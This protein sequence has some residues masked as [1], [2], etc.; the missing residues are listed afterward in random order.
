MKRIITLF[1][2]CLILA[3]AFLACAGSD[4]DA[5][6]TDKK[7]SMLEEVSDA[8]TS[9]AEIT[10][11]ETDTPD[12]ES[13]TTDKSAET[14]E[15]ATSEA[16]STEVVTTAPI[17]AE[18]ETSVPET[19]APSGGGSFGGGGSAPSLPPVVENCDNG[20][21]EV[22]HLA[23]APTCIEIGWNAY[24]TCSRCEYSTYEEIA[25][26]R[27]LGGEVPAFSLDS[28]RVAGQ[29]VF[30][31]GGELKT[32]L[33]DGMASLSE[34]SAYRELSPVG[35]A[36]D[37]L[38]NLE[39]DANISTTPIGTS[40]N[41]SSLTVKEIVDSESV[42]YMIAEDE[43]SYYIAVQK[44]S[45]ATADYVVTRNR[46]FFD[47][48]LDV[49][50]P[51]TAFSFDVIGQ[52]RKDGWAA[53]AND[54][55]LV[56]N[57]LDGYS[58]GNPTSVNVAESEYGDIVSA[59]MAS[60]RVT[61]TP[62]VISDDYD[63][64]NKK[65]EF[66]HFNG[67]LKT[68]HLVTIEMALSKEKIRDHLGMDEDSPL[69]G[70]LF[71]GLGVRGEIAAATNYTTSTTD[72]SDIVYVIWNGALL[73]SYA[74]RDTFDAAYITDLLV[75]GEE[76][77]F[78]C[79]FSSH[80]VSE[81]YRVDGEENKYYH[82]CK[83]CG[84]IGARIFEAYD[85]KKASCT[86]N[87]H[88]SYVSCE[89]CNFTN[90]V[91]DTAKGHDYDSNGKCKTCG[92]KKWTAPD[93]VN[94]YYA[95]N[96][97]TK[98]PTVDGEIKVGEYGIAQRISTTRA[99]K[100]D[101]VNTDWVSD[102][103]DATLASKYI[104]FYF[105]YDEEN[106]YIAMYELGPEL[107]D[108][109]DK[110]N[111]NDVPFR[112][113][114]F[115]QL[116]FDLS[117][118]TSYLYFGGFASNNQWAPLKYSKDGKLYTSNLKTSALIG[119][120]VV[121]TI[122]KSSGKIVGIGDLV[123][124]NGIVNNPTGQWEVVVE[125]KLNKADILS[126]I[127]EV[128]G[129]N[130]TE[131]SDAMWI[132][133]TTNAFKA[134]ADNLNDTN[135]QRFRW[136]G[137]NDITGKQSDYADYGL[138]NSSQEY[139]LD[140][141]VLGSRGTELHAADPNPCVG[142]HRIV[143][144]AAKEPTADTAGWEK[145]ETCENCSYSTY[146]ELPMTGT[147]FKTG[148]ARCVFTPGVPIGKFSTIHDDLYATCVAVND[149][150]KTLLLISID[151]KSMSIT[152][153]DNLKAIISNGTGI[154][155]DNIFISATH[156]HS[157]ATFGTDAV[158]TYNSYK[159]IEQAAKKAIA[160]LTES[161]MLAGTGKT[162][163]MAWVRRY[164]NS[165][166]KMTTVSPGA[167]FSDPTTKSVS[168]ADD[169]L[170]VIRFVR[171]DKKDIILMNWQGHLAHGEGQIAGQ[172][173]ADMA[174]YLREDI[175]SG[176]KDTLVAYFA[177]ASGNL[178]LNAPNKNLVKYSNGTGANNHYEVVA[179]ALAEVTLDVI[180]PAKMTKLEVGKINIVKEV[181]A[182]ILQKDSPEAIAE[183]QARKDAG[184]N[185]KADDYLLARNKK[186][187]IDLRIAAFSF[188]DLGF[189]TAPYEMFDN[190]GMQIKEGSPFKMT[191][192]LTNSDGDYA[193]MPSTEAWTTYGGYETEATYFGNGTAEDFVREYI[194]LLNS[195][196]TN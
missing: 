168:D 147:A 60:V 25:P 100:G 150:E 151:M 140:V 42:R 8:P 56:F 13:D 94:T 46:F 11:A 112:N 21:N 177:G 44:I 22:A 105:A 50:D 19:T 188:G 164:I 62:T 145:Y 64:F 129:T 1:S 127:N 183:A 160:D 185:T 24:V 194:R 108:N 40:G 76:L 156:T 149:G 20:H 175:E 9:E 158:W 61:D 92:L 48:A 155:T 83:H 69:P 47:F 131:L 111:Q 77:G 125:F 187:T 142:G 154:P 66:N 104:D 106:I 43:D 159:K 74:D 79:D 57:F 180:D 63:D 36:T 110:Y 101:D 137:N 58:L 35:Y 136:L 82:S 12:S 173:S 39:K 32:P 144:H 196:K 120:S 14:E 191:F 152:N 81:K 115:F 72:K 192:V 99:V 55:A 121:K 113:N 41:L 167:L 119:E 102:I 132:G 34:Y 3:A 139:M 184:T 16:L 18:T 10:Y 135:N 148:Y 97:S 67:W 162:T 109:G 176:D 134:K 4:V 89:H 146:K 59:M 91:I 181:Y 7:E 30:V 75:F 163:G 90:K 138:A 84:S 23:K 174:Q 193:Y 87:G 15:E 45:G 172:I 37:M 5:P 166:G 124:T 85:E 165:Q 52:G 96:V 189:V 128:Y 114:H 88:N 38:Y 49:N 123:S 179:H 186:D 2:I 143:S 169:T 116:G 86:D 157:T 103:Y 98:T 54:D 182:G 65:P 93:D 26:L 195:L 70:T 80:T 117:D 29:P 161:E 190:N 17:T 133:M 153:N 27:W 6:E 73:D 31:S 33:V 126:V 170:Q 68:S 122:D 118:A 53:S 95:F 51:S 107:I 78:G 141:V 71:F 171:E 130:Y 28:Y 178:N